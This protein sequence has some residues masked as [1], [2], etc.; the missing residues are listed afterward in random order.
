[1]QAGKRSR[2]HSHL[3]QTHSFFWKEIR[4]FSARM[5]LNSPRVFPILLTVF[6]NDMSIDLGIISAGQ[7]SPDI[8]SDIVMSVVLLVDYGV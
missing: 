7:F 2:E 3:G 6:S 4:L 1:M 8:A 5:I